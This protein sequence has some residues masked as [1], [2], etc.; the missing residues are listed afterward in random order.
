MPKH[1][2]RGQQ[3]HRATGDDC[4]HGMVLDHACPTT[5]EGVAIRRDVAAAVDAESIDAAAED[6][7]QTPAPA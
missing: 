2:Q 1:R 7:Q 3:Q 6:G 4:G 5:A